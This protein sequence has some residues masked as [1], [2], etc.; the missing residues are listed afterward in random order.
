[1]INLVKN[2]IDKE[3]NKIIEITDI[4]VSKEEYDDLFSNFKCCGKI[5]KIKEMSD[6]CIEENYDLM[7]FLSTE[8]LNK[9]LRTKGTDVRKFE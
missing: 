6:I 4:V 8:N 2:S 9:T 3:G 1:M 7:K 5:L